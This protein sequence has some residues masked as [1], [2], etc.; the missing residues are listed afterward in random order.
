MRKSANS[1]NNGAREMEFGSFDGGG[2]GER[3][4]IVFVEISNIFTMED[5]FFLKW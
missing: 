2:D 4:G 5:N 3:D 1:V